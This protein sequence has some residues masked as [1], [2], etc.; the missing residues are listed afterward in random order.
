MTKQENFIFKKNSY[1]TNI[2]KDYKMAIYFYDTVL[3]FS[4]ILDYDEV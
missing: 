2:F 1:K 3:K 4:N